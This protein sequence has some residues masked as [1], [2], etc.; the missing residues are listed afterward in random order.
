MF[1]VFSQVKFLTFVDL[2]FIKALLK[3]PNLNLC[4]HM[5]KSKLEAY[6]EILKAIAEQPSTLSTIA[7]NC[8]MDCTYLAGSLSFLIENQLVQEHAV[9]K[10][11]CYSI[12]HRGVAVL[13]TLTVSSLLERLQTTVKAADETLAVI[14]TLDMPKK[15]KVEAKNIKF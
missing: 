8:N 5:R 11:T 4:S 2:E 7:Y 1:K 3:K 12:T 10:K 6:Q 9:G 13:K 14:S 15:K